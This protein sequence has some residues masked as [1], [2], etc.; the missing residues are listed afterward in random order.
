MYSDPSVK[1][2]PDARGIRLAVGATTKTWVLSKRI[3]GKVRSVTLGSWPDLP[4]VYAARDVAV[5]KMAAVTTRTDA[6]STGIHTLND[7]LESH[8]KRSKA[9]DRTKDEYRAQVRNN[10]ADLFA[11]KIE[12]ITLDH[13]E[14][15]VL[16]KHGIATQKHLAQII[17]TSFKRAAAVRRCFNV[18]DDLKVDTKS[19]QP[20][21]SVNFDADERWPALDMIEAKKQQNRIIGAAFELML[22]T[23]LRAGNVITLRWDDIDFKARKLRVS[24]LKNGRVGM[25]PLADRVVALLEALPKHSEWVFPQH[26]TEKHIFH[27]DRLKFGDNILRP[28]DCRRLFT[29]AARRADLP[30]YVIDQLRGDVEKGVQ[31]IYDQGSA[32]HRHANAIAKQTEVECG[33]LPSLNVVQIGGRR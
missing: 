33:A 15:V 6:A 10:M 5:E 20:D 9:S 22:F 14:E 24:R 16:G 18:A 1:P 21:N 7:A 17:R 25:F 11:M 4:T 8:I 12:D 29:T 13:L 2:D 26:D 23:G 32:S 27:P 19:Y 30:A 3:D 28:H 31:G